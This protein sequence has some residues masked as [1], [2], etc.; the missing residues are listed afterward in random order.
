MCPQNTGMADD[1][2]KA[3]LEPEN[4][5]PGKEEQE[6]LDPAYAPAT[7]SQKMGLTFYGA[8]ALIGILVFLIVFM[9]VPG[10][11]TSANIL[12]V[13]NTWTLQ[14]YMD[15]DGELVPTITGSPIT[16]VFNNKGSVRGSAGCN[17]YIANYTTRNLA[18]TISLPVMTGN[19]CE[20]QSVMQQESAYTGDLAQA[21]EFRVSESN[22]NL[23][24]KTGRAVLTFISTG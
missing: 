10:I 18:I 20:N 23:Y 2:G 3:P 7:Q 21:A 14:S 6:D 8:L 19:T 1:T 17:D 11:R 24:D 13:K 22:L 4:P 12:L 15:A 9:N 5:E 16:A